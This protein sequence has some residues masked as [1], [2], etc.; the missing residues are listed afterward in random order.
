MPGAFPR[1]TPGIPLAERSGPDNKL[2]RA[3]VVAENRYSSPMS[4][5]LS[6]NRVSFPVGGSIKRASRRAN[7]LEINADR[8]SA[9]RSFCNVFSDEETSVRCR[10]RFRWKKEKH[11]AVL[12]GTFSS[13]SA[14]LKRISLS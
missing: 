8:D 9:P 7:D 11:A 13:L 2:K 5:F 10:V 3:Y 4:P 14:S 1:A 6:C 12:R